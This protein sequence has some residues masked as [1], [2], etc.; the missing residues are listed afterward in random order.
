M[1]GCS[2]RQIFLTSSNDLRCSTLALYRH[3]DGPRSNFK[4]ALQ[5]TFCLGDAEEGRCSEGGDYFH[6]H[7]RASISLLYF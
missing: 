2:H 3:D 1:A 4:W 5:T 7:G 6:G